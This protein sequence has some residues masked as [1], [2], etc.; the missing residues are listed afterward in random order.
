MNNCDTYYRNKSNKNEWSDIKSKEI[1]LFSY[2]KKK[3][4]TNLAKRE[5]IVR[6]HGYTMVSKKEDRSII[7]GIAKP[8]KESTLKRHN[9]SESSD[10]EN[11][12][13]RRWKTNEFKEFEFFSH[14]YD[15][16]H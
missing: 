2:I 4:D 3:V 5:S 12:W 6:K 11:R 1:S 8:K 9:K 10:W 14:F 13:E 16:I 7:N 15:E